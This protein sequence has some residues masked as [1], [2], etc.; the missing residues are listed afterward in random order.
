M[1]GNYK[2][3]KTMKKEYYII[4]GWHVRQYCYTVAKM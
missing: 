3:R 1:D 4:Y 2:H